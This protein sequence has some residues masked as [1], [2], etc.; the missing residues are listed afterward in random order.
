VD[1]PHWARDMVM[2]EI[3]RSINDCIARIDRDIK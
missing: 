3:E 1:I 2:D